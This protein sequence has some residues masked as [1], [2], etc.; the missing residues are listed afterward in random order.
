MEANKT[1]AT[2]IST[3]IEKE[4]PNCNDS[5]DNLKSFSILISESVIVISSKR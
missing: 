2:I 4:N 5:I 3:I 1:E